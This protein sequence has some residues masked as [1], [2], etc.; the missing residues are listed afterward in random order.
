V[1]RAKDVA[2][3][4]KVIVGRVGGC[5]SFLLPES[6]W[7]GSAGDYERAGALCIL[8]CAAPWGATD[9]IRSKESMSKRVM[10]EVTGLMSRCLAV[11]QVLKTPQSGRVP[12]L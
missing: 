6:C 1:I 5:F 8:R 10:A 7:I 2:E 12:Q 4:G 3:L 9:V 11:S